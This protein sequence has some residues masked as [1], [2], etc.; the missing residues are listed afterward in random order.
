M[1][2][3]INR[4]VLGI[5][6]V[7]FLLAVKCLFQ[8]TYL[9]YIDEV[10][11]LW[12]L[13]Y[14]GYKLISKTKSARILNITI[15]FAVIMS[16][17][18]LAGNIIFGYQH[19]YFQVMVDIFLFFKPYI[20]FAASYMFFEDLVKTQSYHIGIVAVAKAISLIIFVGLVVS[21][22]L[23]LPALAFYDHWAAFRFIKT[24]VFFA[25]Y[26]GYLAV[27]VSSM[28]MILLM[29]GYKNRKYI[30]MDIIILACTQSGLAFI[31]ICLIALF[32]II[33]KG[34]KITWYHIAFLSIIG[35]IIG[36]NEIR[37]YLLQDTAARS[38]LLR[39][40]F[41]TAKNCFPLG[42]GFST[43]GG[44]AAQKYYSKLYT[45]YDFGRFWGMGIDSDVDFLHDCY[46]PTI[47]G[48]FGFLGL[49]TYALYELSLFRTINRLEYSKYHKSALMF[50][51]I[52]LLAMN[53]GQGEFSGALGVLYMILMPFILR[54][55]EFG[56]KTV[57]RWN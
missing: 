9:R 49:L 35:I 55:A 4:K 10:I 7:T 31:A 45:Q 57:I 33:Y 36:W 13:L 17:L 8:I 24:Y 48:Q 23:D 26:P 12:A 51:F 19:G 53:L 29:D 52:F 54:D 47:I 22:V 50:G 11:A 3:R 15:W 6:A 18:G 46:Y 21:Y 32:T 14:F 28:I 27:F 41:V 39:Y 1:S 34:K 42:A 40:G 56:E 20:V 2:F 25:K 5:I 30:Y 44:S 38:V 37:V 16:T 43:Y